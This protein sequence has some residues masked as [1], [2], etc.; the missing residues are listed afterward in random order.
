MVVVSL[1]N[2]SSGEVACDLH[3]HSGIPFAVR[4]LGGRRSFDHFSP[5]GGNAAA[6]FSRVATSQFLTVLQ[7]DYA[8]SADAI[9]DRPA[10][11]EEQN[12][13]AASR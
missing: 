3:L 6:C 12:S 1:G 8:I 5:T 13:I 9:I 10:A 7:L 11:R 4:M 2:R